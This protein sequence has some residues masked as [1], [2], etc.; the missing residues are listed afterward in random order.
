MTTR[1]VAVGLWL[2]SVV[3]TGGAAQA[4][5]RPAAFPKVPLVSGSIPYYAP[6]MV[7]VE[8]NQI[9]YV[10]FDGNVS[11]GYDRLY[12]W[13]P[14]DS[15]YRTP[16]AF[17][18]NSE[19]KRFGPIDFKPRHDKDEIRIGWSFSW[20]RHGGAYQHF[21]YLTG[22]TRKGTSAIYPV[23][24]FHCDYQRQPRGGAR[25][26]PSLVDITIPGY[27]GASVWTNMPRALEP[28]HT[29]NYYMTTRLVREKDHTLVRF[30]GVLNYAHNHAVTVRAL[31]RETVCTLVVSPYLERP[32]YSNDLTW[33]EAIGT[34][35]DVKLEYRW[36][37]LDWN[38][39]CPGLRAYP[40]RDIAVRAS[41]FPIT[42]FDD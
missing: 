16:K 35:V 23:F 40:R 28:W 20:A 41:P 19:S 27:M 7:D 18:M 17:R 33:A 11:N 29:L 34:G 6:V 26:S 15:T 39:S 2:I 30:M 5:E 42:R 13:I 36:Y 37:D 22:Q 31:P 10:L 4:R 1:I 38:I 14:D 9:G 32:V 21:D 24:Y 25:P 12:F 3:L 8:T